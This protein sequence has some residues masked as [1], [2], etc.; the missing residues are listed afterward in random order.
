MKTLFVF[1]SISIFCI[2]C[3]APLAVSQQSK[4]DYNSSLQEIRYEV[5]DLRHA[6]NHAKV[7]I[8]L[9]DEQLKEKEKIAKTSKAIP[10]TEIDRRIAQ[11]ETSLSRLSEELR[12][13]SSHADQ[14]SQCFT[15]YSAKITT[16]EKSL[17]EQQKL[18]V[19]IGDLKS[20]LLTLKEE[21]TCKTYKVKS[22]DSLEKIARAHKVSVK[23]LQEK[24]HLQQ[25]RIFVGQEL[26]IPY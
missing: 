8:Q 6:L 24:N 3:T 5:A 26:I 12:E 18:L 13:L 20:S 23:Q 22:G 11:V 15:D 17:I 9:L 10:N 1:C 21:E 16:L 25:D 19:Q 7:D 2:S 4:H 14:T